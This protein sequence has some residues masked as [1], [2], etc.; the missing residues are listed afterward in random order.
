MLVKLFEADYISVIWEK[1]QKTY[2]TADKESKEPKNI[3]ITWD[4][5]RLLFTIQVNWKLK[6]FTSDF[7]VI[8]WEHGLYE[9]KNWREWFIL[10]TAFR[11]MGYIIWP[12]DIHELWGMNTW[13]QTVFEVDSF[14]AD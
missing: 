6:T 11:E 12:E 13:I 4:Y 7:E 5:I 1:I 9:L 3:E 8:D 10:F 14:N 2:V